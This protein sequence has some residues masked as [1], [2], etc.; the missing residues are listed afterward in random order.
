MNENETKQTAKKGL[1]RIVFSR[2]GIFTLLIL[3]Q[4][5][6]F[7]AVGFYLQEYATYI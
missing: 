6:I 2:A 5:G 3:L 1:S 4:L 7:V